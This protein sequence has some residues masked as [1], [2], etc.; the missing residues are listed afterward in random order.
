MNQ[1][2]NQMYQNL[3]IQIGA[4]LF[5]AVIP[6][7]YPCVSLVLLCQKPLENSC[8]GSKCIS[9]VRQS[10]SFNNHTPCLTKNCLTWLGNLPHL[11]VQALNGFLWF[12][13]MTQLEKRKMC[14]YWERQESVL[15][16]LKFTPN[17]SS[18]NVLCFSSAIGISV[19]PS[20]VTAGKW[21]SSHFMLEF[22]YSLLKIRHFFQI[23]FWCATGSLSGNE[24]L[25]QQTFISHHLPDAVGN[26]E[27]VSDG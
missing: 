24:M 11:P 3:G 12:L 17:G 23:S 18:Q 7:S 14:C 6:R 19:Q 5:K 2:F 20:R 9:H 4:A 1:N 21:D 26:A 22:W 8:F 25:I 10:V 13:K 16:V 15:Q 27:T